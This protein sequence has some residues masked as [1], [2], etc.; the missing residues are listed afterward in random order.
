MLYLVWIQMLYFQF[1]D[2]VLKEF[3]GYG[4]PTISRIARGKFCYE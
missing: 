1:D 4:D 3:I 2:Q